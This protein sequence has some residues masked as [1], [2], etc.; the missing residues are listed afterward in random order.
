MI[1]VI[2]E[3]LL[4]AS[5]KFY[6]DLECLLVKTK[7]SQNGPEKSYTERKTIHVPGGYSLDLVTSHDSNKNKHRFY[8]GED[9][10]KN[11]VMT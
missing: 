1:V 4:R 11:Y 8:R 5:H 2:Q 6:L 10:T 7:S 9:S 3:C